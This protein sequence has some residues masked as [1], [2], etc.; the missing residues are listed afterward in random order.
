MLTHPLVLHAGL[1]HFTH[2]AFYARW[3]G[4]FTLRWL[5][6]RAIQKIVIA[7]MT[8]GTFETMTHPQDS[9]DSGDW[10]TKDSLDLFEFIWIEFMLEIPIQ[11]T[12]VVQGYSVRCK[13][14][15]SNEFWETKVDSDDSGD[16]DPR[17]SGL[18]G[19]R[20]TQAIQVIQMIRTR[21]TQG[22]HRGSGDSNSAD[23]RDLGIW[24]RRT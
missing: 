7:H 22:I 11:G 6:G 14:F 2:R 16:S 20:V 1:R 21:R 19:L 12:Q 10:D 4:G 8:T 15:I 23:S 18:I 3:F 9:R 5:T 17:G 24:I 13:G